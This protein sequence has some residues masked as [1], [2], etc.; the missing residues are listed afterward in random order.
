MSTDVAGNDQSAR[1]DLDSQT[2]LGL[3]R[4]PGKYHVSTPH[5]H[6]YDTTATHLGQRVKR[7]PLF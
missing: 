1:N 3:A 2:A 5:K 4:S 6:L 7:P